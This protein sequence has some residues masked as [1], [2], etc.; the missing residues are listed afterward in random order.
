MILEE[1][2]KKKK[3]EREKGKKTKKSFAQSKLILLPSFSRDARRGISMIR[4]QAYR[5]GRGD[6]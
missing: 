1:E 6:W 4:R 3:K 2:K 5:G